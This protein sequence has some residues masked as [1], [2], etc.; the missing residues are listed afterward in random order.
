MPGNTQCHFVVTKNWTKGKEDN[1]NDLVIPSLP[2]R[3]PAFAESDDDYAKLLP[4]NLSAAD[5]D[6]SQV[7]TGV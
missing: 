5:L 1:N 4:S 7:V 3:T 6:L 2:L